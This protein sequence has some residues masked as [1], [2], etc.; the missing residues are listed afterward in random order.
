MQNFK[1]RK[2]SLKAD[3]VIPPGSTKGKL[4]LGDKSADISIAVKDGSSFIDEKEFN[5]ALKTV[6]FLK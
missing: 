3:I 6:G 5:D 1:I 4:I 2:G